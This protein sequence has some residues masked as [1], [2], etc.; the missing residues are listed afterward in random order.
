MPSRLQLGRARRDCQPGPVSG[1]S[2]TRTTPVATRSAATNESH[3][4]EAAHVP[5]LE[6]RGRARADRLLSHDRRDAV[7]CEVV[8][9]RSDGN[10]KRARPLVQL[11]RDAPPSDRNRLGERRRVRRLGRVGRVRRRHVDR[12][13]ATR[14]PSIA[15]RVEIHV[16]ARIPAP[17]AEHEVVMAV[18]DHRRIGRR[19]LSGS[20]MSDRS[21]RDRRRRRAPV[22]GRAGPPLDA[23]GRFIV[24]CASNGRKRG[25]GRAS[26]RAVLMDIRHAGARQDRRDARVHERD[27]G[28]QVVIYTGSDEYDDVAQA[29]A[30]ARTASCTRARS[31]RLS[32][33]TRCSCCAR[34]TRTRS[35]TRS[36]YLTRAKRCTASSSSSVLA[37]AASLSP[38]A[39]A[40]A[41]QWR[42]WSSRICTASD[43]RAV[44]AA[45]I[46][47][48]M[49]MQ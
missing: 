4:A 38:D 44:V 37:A 17:R 21:H 32:S 33:P 49:S 15:R 22:V 19:R 10:R 7:G 35:P 26:I 48:R 9:G 30:A 31:R 11:G 45:E 5:V 27:A 25:S 12:E 2:G 42:T 1:D 40:S 29:D 23:D 43:S 13:E 16:P 46:C 14:V 18:D 39:S 20:A 47:V 28:Q 8:G 36:S 34:T 24:G 6:S 41:T 3:R